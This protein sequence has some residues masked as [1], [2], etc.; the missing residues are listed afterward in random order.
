[1]F[2]SKGDIIGNDI[3]FEGVLKNK[4]TIPYRIEKAN[5]YAKNLNLNQLI[6]KLKVAEVD[7][8][9]TFE[10]LEDFNLR[11]II[12]KN[13]VLKADAVQLRNIHATNFE[14][15]TSLNEKGVFDVNNFRFNI[16]QGLLEGNLAYNLENNA[17]GI[18]LDANSISANDL[19]LA[20]FDLNNQ[21]HGD[22]TGKVGLN[23]EGTDFNHCMQTL[24]GNAIFNVK[25]GK[26]PKLGSLE[27][28]LKAGNLVK[29][30]LTGLS[31]NGIVDLLAPSKT[32]EFENIYGSVRIKDGVAR[33]IEIA[34]KGNDLNLFVSGSYNF[35][36][37]IADMEVLG[38]LSRKISTML[39]PI[40]NVSI[41]TLF[42]IIPGVDLSKDSPILER[43]N[44]IPGVELSD[45]LYRKFIAE[46]KG[47][48]NGEDYVTSFKW[49]N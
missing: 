40:G 36:T 24:N 25:D 19:T 18:N 33:N 20:L 26:M 5:F 17:M 27:Y 34:T 7:S 10:S 4:L 12:A 22:L 14:A 21:I 16:A 15:E 46:I 47:N 30:G 35:A 42:N 41:N 13:F 3:V 38:L 48:I 1:M 11:T 6:D 45:K 23:C 37:S 43:I 28:L 49:I 44:K 31:I 2:N 8:V 9:S 39:G 32:G 29:G